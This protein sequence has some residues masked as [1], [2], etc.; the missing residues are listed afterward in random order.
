[1]IDV[2]WC[3]GL[4]SIQ[5]RS[6]CPLPFYFFLLNGLFWLLFD[7]GH[8]ACLWTWAC[9]FP[10]SRTEA[11]AA[12]S[13]CSVMPQEFYTWPL[14]RAVT[15]AALWPGFPMCGNE[16][17]PSRST[18]CAPS[19]SLEMATACAWAQVWLRVMQTSVSSVTGFTRRLVSVFR[20]KLG[21]LWRW[22]KFLKS[23]NKWWYI[24]VLLW[25]L[26]SIMPTSQLSS[27]PC[28]KTYCDLSEV[29]F[30]LWVFLTLENQ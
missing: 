25:V 12:A 24:L 17:C 7:K 20:W 10:R 19:S 29:F 9:S 15:P 23:A 11:P 6:C 5:F 28:L 22:M 27:C 14:F 3:Y 13:K 30:P 4:V 2:H 18:S 1:M 21:N 16:V 8:V 26:E